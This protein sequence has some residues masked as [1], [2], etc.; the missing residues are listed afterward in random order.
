MPQHKDS[1]EQL[2]VKSLSFATNIFGGWQSGHGSAHL[3]KAATDAP[4]DVPE[5]Q[6]FAEDTQQLSD[7]SPLLL[8]TNEPS[9]S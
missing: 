5:P 6:Q 4:R 2:L 7:P 3:P 8:E 1:S 9:I